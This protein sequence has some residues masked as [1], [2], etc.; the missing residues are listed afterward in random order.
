MNSE[1]PVRLS[2]TLTERPIISGQGIQRKRWTEELNLGNGEVMK[3][4]SIKH[5]EALE[6]L[7]GQL[8]EL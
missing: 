6:D 3:L 7:A 1:A 5:D 8:K 2:S 4:N